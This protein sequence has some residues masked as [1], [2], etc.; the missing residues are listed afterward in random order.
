MA[1]ASPYCFL[2]DK[3]RRKRGVP[4]WCKLIQRT[5][6]I[7]FHDWG[8]RSF[9]PSSQTRL[10]GPLRPTHCASRSGLKKDATS[11]LSVALI[12][13]LLLANQELTRGAL[14]TGGGRHLLVRRGLWVVVG[15]ARMDRPE[16][17]GR[18]GLAVPDWLT[19]VG[20]PEKEKKRKGER[21]A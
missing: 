13:G 3:R 19:M 20:P 11:H 16:R 10:P 6:F 5:A 2:L 4:D 18:P 12:L 9:H 8:L 21:R 14:D 17:K 1:V 15:P 7:R